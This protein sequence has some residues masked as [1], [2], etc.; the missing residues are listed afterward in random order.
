VNSETGPM[1][2]GYIFYGPY[3]GRLR[4]LLWLNANKRKNGR[5]PLLPPDSV[6]FITRKRQTN[7]TVSILSTDNPHAVN[8]RG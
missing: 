4:I 5:Q 2:V 1:R 3:I 8:N 6:G 7:H